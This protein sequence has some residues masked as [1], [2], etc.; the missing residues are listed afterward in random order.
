MKFCRRIARQLFFERQKADKR[1]IKEL[2]RGSVHNLLTTSLQKILMSAAGLTMLVSPLFGAS[3]SKITA[4]GDQ[5]K[6]QYDEAKKLH[7]ITTTKIQG[8]NAFNAFKE[9]TLSSNEIANLHLPD[10]TSN[11]LNFVKS[12][13]DIQGTLNAVKD[14]KIGGNLYFLSSEGLV[15]GSGGVINAG[16]FYAMTPSKSFMKK[17]VNDKGFVSKIKDDELNLILEK[18]IGN[19]N[20]PKNEGV[21]IDEYGEIIIQGQINTVNG[22]GLYAGGSYFLSSG[23]A[24]RSAV[25]IDSGAK[26]NTFSK[27]QLN[28]FKNLVNCDGISIPTASDLVE[29][30]GNIELVSVQD[31]THNHVSILAAELGYSNFHAVEAYSKVEVRGDLQSRGDINIQSYAVS[32][33]VTK[34]DDKGVKSFDSYDKLSK[35]ASEVSFSGSAKAGGKITIEAIADN[36][37]IS[38]STTL[39]DVLLS[40][41]ALNINAECLWAETKSKVDIKKDSILDAKLQLKIDAITSSSQEQGCKVSAALKKGKVETS[42]GA[43]RLPTGSAVYAE[44][45]SESIVNFD[46]TAISRA[47]SIVEDEASISLRSES[48]SSLDVSATAEVVENVAPMQAALGIGKSTNKATL[49]IGKNASFETKQD[50]EIVAET[51]SE[52][53]VEAA[54][55]GSRHDYFL[56]A[57]GISMFN[58]DSIVNIEKTNINLNNQKDS[59]SIKANNNVLG[60]ELFAEAGITSE[61]PWQKVTRELKENVTDLLLEKLGVNGFLEVL[62]GISNDPVI[63]MGQKFTN[64]TG[65][66]AYGGG[67]HNSKI[68]IKPGAKIITTGDL[69]LD[70]KTYINDT[71]YDATSF[72]YPETDEFSLSAKSGLG[73]AALISNYDYNSQIIF[74]DSTSSAKTQIVGNSVTINSQVEQPYNRAKIVVDALKAAALHLKNL[75]TSE[76]YKEIGERLANSIDNLENGKGSF[77]DTLALLGSLKDF[78]GKITI[79]DDGLVSR[80]IAMLEYTLAFKDQTNFLNYTVNSYVNSSEGDTV[81]DFAGSAFVGHNKAKSNLFVGKNTII[82][83]KGDGENRNIAL[84][85]KTD[86][87]NTAMV[88]GLPLVGQNIGGEEAVSIGGSAI[89]HTNDSVSELLIAD[90]AKI[91]SENTENLSITSDNSFR[92]VDLIIGTSSAS[93]GFNLM[94]SVITGE[95][96][97]NVLIDNSVNLAADTLKMYAYNNTTANNIVGSI[98]LTDSIGV[99]VGAAVTSLTKETQVLYE[100]NDLYWQKKRKELKLRTTDPANSEVSYSVAIITA[101]VV[102]AVAKTSGTINSIGIAGSVGIDDR[103]TYNKIA[104]KATMFNDAADTSTIET[105]TDYLKFKLLGKIGSA[106]PFNLSNKSGYSNREDKSNQIINNI[107]GI[108]SLFQQQENE[109]EAREHDNEASLSLSANGS[110]GVNKI[111]NTTKVDLNKAHIKFNKKDNAKIDVSAINSA[112]HLAFAGAAGIIAQGGNGQGRTVGVDG[113]VALNLIDNKTESLV[114]DTNIIDAKQI[115]L[116]AI[117]G[118]DSIAA[119]LGLQVIASSYDTESAGSGAVNTSVNLID[120]KVTSKLDNA[121]VK[122]VN[123]SNKANMVVTAYEH[124]NQITNGVSAAAGN[125]KGAVGVSV[126]VSKINNTLTAEVSQGTYKNMGNVEVN[127]LQASTIVNAGVA[128]GVSK[129]GHDELVTFGGAGAGVYSELTNTTNANIKNATINAESLSANARDIR[130]TDKMV[131]NYEKN[132]VRDGSDV[133]F[134]K[135]DTDSIDREGKPFYT[136]LDTATGTTDLLESATGRKGSLLVTAAV[137]GTYGEVAVGLGAAINEVRNEFNVNISNSTINSDSFTAKAL[138][139][140]TSIDVAAGAAIAGS[141]YNDNQAKGSGIGSAAWSDIRNKAKVTIEHNNIT[142]KDLNFR[143]LNE[144]L[145]VGVAGAV[146][147]STG[148]GLGAAGASVAYTAIDNTANTKLADNKINVKGKNKGD[149]SVESE[150][151]SNLWGV[152]IELGVNSKVSVGGSVAINEIDNGATS[153]ISSST[154][155]ISGTNYKSLNVLATDSA[156]IKSLSGMVSQGSKAAVGGSVA[157]NKIKGDTSTELDNVK[158][159]ADSTKLESYS[160][161]NILTLA[162]GSS[163]SGTGAAEGSVVVDNNSRNVTSTIN[164]SNTDNATGTVD[165][166]SKRFGNTGSLAV[167]VVG[168][169]GGAGGAGVSVNKMTGTAKT[170]LSNNNLTVKNLNASS[171]SDQDITN[172]GVAG[173]GGGILGLTG[174]VAVNTL[175]NDTIT[176]VSGGGKIES[177]NNIGVIAQSDDSIKNYAGLLNVGFNVGAGGGANIPNANLDA[178]AN[179]NRNAFQSF[180]GKIGSGLNAASGKV[181]GIASKLGGIGVGVSVSVN[182]L[183][184]KTNSFVNGVDLTAKG[185]DSNNKITVKD[186]IENSAINDAYVDSKTVNI[187]SSL[188]GDR[189]ERQLSGIVVDSSSTHTVK[190]F[191]A[192]VGVTGKVG[193]NANVNVN[194]IGGETNA[195]INNSTINKGLNGKTAGDVNVYAKDYTNTSGLIG[196]ATL[197]GTVGVGA[198]ADTNKV[199]RNTYAKATNIK[200]GSVAKAFDV[201]AMSKQG[202]SSFVVGLAASLKVSVAGNVSVTL[203]NSITSSLIDN[204]NISVNSMDSGADHYARSHVMAG[205]AGIGVAAAGVGAA[206]VVTN[207]KSQSLAKVENSVIGIN[208]GYAGDVKINSNNDDK[209]EVTA[210][211]AA[212]G[213]YAGVAGTVDVNYMENQVDTTVAS[214]TIGTSGSRAKSIEIKSKDA[215]EINTDFGSGGIGAAGA[216][217]SVVVNTFNGQT[218]TNITDSKVFSTNDV[219]VGATEERNSKEF[220]VTVS[221]GVGGLSANVLV[222]NSGKKLDFSETDSKDVSKDVDKSLNMADQAL[223]NDYV[224]K[225]HQGVLSDA[226]LKKILGNQPAYFA[227]EDGKAITLTKVDNSTIDSKSGKVSSNTKA[228]GTIDIRPNGGSLGLGAVMG[229]FGFIY[230]NKNVNSQFTNSTINAAKGIDIFSNANGSSYSRMIQGAVGGAT[231]SGAFSYLYLNN[232]TSVGVAGSNL[233]N[234]ANAFLLQLQSICFFK[235]ST[236]VKTEKYSLIVEALST[237]NSR[238]NTVYISLNKS[239][240]FV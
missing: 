196:N 168:S 56:P 117:N 68:N 21:I 10:N 40:L 222:I 205:S 207:D 108:P 159:K 91:G 22:I 230:D 85:S 232:N 184:N 201:K 86:I 215:S 162:L 19:Y 188:A 20:V 100:D 163:V 221:V 28:A 111:T 51:N 26:L 3:Q 112:H 74:D 120:N 140:T 110:V 147:A 36:E 145:L 121:Y 70:S 166:A 131:E 127:A 172:I 128:L 158:F 67:T 49:T 216:G 43:R 155:G 93:K 237:P 76:E 160:D 79:G 99:G 89:A 173:S 50:V 73:L 157:V 180:F 34:I 39:K 77:S 14:S 199:T 6:I 5:T 164:K 203:L 114:S 198:S 152:A 176:E 2:R 97:S 239:G 126:D 15:L 191:L 1:H 42:K 87:T 33:T 208:N 227:S 96:K 144:S 75:F 187:N 13:I 151:K 183:N 46:G 225:Y 27:D 41:V 125:Q 32:G 190:S 213:I 175:N 83:S 226:E 148:G 169:K 142:S 219:N 141:D 150:N 156:D 228:D 57:I 223:S 8:K 212:G 186:N 59:F 177:E 30:E 98:M 48:N 16:A 192:S 103:S 233:T 220:G 178:N 92:P 12:K 11:L 60:D 124:D 72:N 18:K 104:N 29:K 224:S 95:S 229:N 115:N 25:Y 122:A 62:F 193:V 135:I 139:Y 119:A 137:S 202:L 240:R 214:S 234:K 31:N 78:A 136:N 189:K 84:N 200:S 238:V 167:V 80:L 61:Y 143:T 197:S 185:K 209:Y 182:T 44:S 132:L 107:N 54:S 195:Y 88:G 170:K 146:S 194:T 82:N 113:S 106:L 35:V 154:V 123:T 174:S 236:I 66:V 138:S 71:K 9:F 90:S 235:Q 218:N 58:S 4:L 217:A 116:L 129:G 63:P 204:A 55:K 102:E 47:D 64:L 81:L 7:T 211:S 52:S 134:I 53:Y 181:G 69:V 133:N 109:Q 118:G 206:V 105:G 101:D 17:F 153:S 161:S 65:A 210:F 45:K 171:I 94:A 179:A 231:Y 37:N 130:S 149:F 38:G 24:Y 23:E 165:V